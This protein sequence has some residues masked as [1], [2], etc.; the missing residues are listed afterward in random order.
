V[1]PLW[2]YIPAA[3]FVLL[4]NLEVL[5]FD[6]MTRRMA[7][8]IIF[9]PFLLLV[10]MVIIGRYIARQILNGEPMDFLCHVVAITVFMFAVRLLLMMDKSMILGQK[11]SHALFFFYMAVIIG[12]YFAVPRLRA[13]I[14]RP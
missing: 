11:A 4:S 1:P 14:R 9:A 3:A 8:Y 12:A 13:W 5:G 6:L 10:T 7:M 2:K